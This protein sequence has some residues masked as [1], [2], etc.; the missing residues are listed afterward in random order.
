MAALQVS[1]RTNDQFSAIGR[2]QGP[3]SARIV[4]SR[5]RGDIQ[6]SFLSVR[7]LDWGTDDEHRAK[8]VD[9]LAT[10]VAPGSHERRERRAHLPA[11]RDLTEDVLQVAA[12][13]SR[14]R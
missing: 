7:T 4:K 5:D 10:Q 3:V 2:L 9:E 13:A 12:A 6:L 14:A 11:F 8:A 1:N